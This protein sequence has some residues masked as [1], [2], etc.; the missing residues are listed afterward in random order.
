MD[1]KRKLYI[2]GVIIDDA[3]YTLETLYSKK[4]SSNTNIYAKTC[5]YL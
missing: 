2:A 3:F 4:R 1:T 5:I